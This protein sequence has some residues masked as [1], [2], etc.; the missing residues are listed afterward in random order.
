VFPADVRIND[1]PV[2]YI[3]DTGAGITLVHARS[4]KRLGLNLTEPPSSP[5]PAP[6]SV[7]VGR[8]ELCRLT[9]GRETHT[10]RL[11]TVHLPWPWA[12]LFDIDGVI[13]WPD[14]ADDFFAI[15]AADDAIKSLDCLPQCTNGWLKLPLY[16]HTDVLALEVPRTDGKTGVL[17]VDTGNPDG[18]SLSPARWKEWRAAHRHAHGAWQFNFMPGSGPTIGRQYVAEDVAIGPLNWWQVVIRKARVTETSIA[19]AADVFEGSIGIEAL[20]QLNLIIDRTNHLAYMR[21][22]PDWTPSHVSRRSD[23]P[24]AAACTNS[25]VRLGFQ[26]HEY[27]DLAQAAFDSGKFGAAITNLTR[28]LELQPQNAGARAMRG[29]ALFRLHAGEGSATDLDRSIGDLTRALEQDPGITPAYYWRGSIYYVG[30]RWDDALADYRRFCAK[31][32][33]AA[34]YARFFIWLIG[35][36]QGE[37]AAVDREL[38]TSFAGGQK[39]ASRWEKMV[40]SFLLGRMSEDEFLASALADSD[41]GRHCEA[42]FYAGMKRRLSGDPAKARDYLERCLATDR[43]DFDEYNF[44]AAELRIL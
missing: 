9:A 3:Y 20:R 8:T 34:N 11:A 23:I 35:S 27:A 44:A 18:I 19:D 43:K 24:W 38:E 4:A 14:L 25:T 10:L 28:L 37:Q 29:E 1:K 13:G 33:E 41:S 15:D 2:R 32:P 16:R 21:R 30:Q 31:V 42:W 40:S 22:N 36:R 6:G 7:N 26:A 39:K 12:G 17:E 5:K